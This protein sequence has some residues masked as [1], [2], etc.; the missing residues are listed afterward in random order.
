ML[1]SLKSTIR[2]V[3]FRSYM[4]I[5]DRVDDEDEDAGNWLSKVTADVLG[6]AHSRREVFLTG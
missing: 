2:G 4:L 1:L 6:I 3:S 5:N